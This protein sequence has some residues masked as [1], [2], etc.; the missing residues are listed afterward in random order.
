MVGEGC[1][2]MVIF[3]LKGRKEDTQVW[4]KMT[5]LKYC[6]GKISASSQFLPY[7]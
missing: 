1:G 4:I 2:E 5:T 6:R 7:L 3:D